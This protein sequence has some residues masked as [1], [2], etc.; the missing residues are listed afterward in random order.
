MRYAPFRADQLA[1]ACPV[2]AEVLSLDP[3]TLARSQ[4]RSGCSRPLSARRPRRTDRLADVGD[5]RAAAD[6]VRGLPRR[7]VFFAEWIEPP[8]APGT[9]YR[10]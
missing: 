10:R 4:T 8:S 1:T 7:R 6:S 9:G 3:R 5:D 2:A